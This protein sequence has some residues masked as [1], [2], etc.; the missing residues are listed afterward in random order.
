MGLQRKA[1]FLGCGLYF[2]NLRAEIKSFGLG[3]VRD[4]NPV[5]FLVSVVFA[6][7]VS[8]TQQCI[9]SWRRPSVILG[10]PAT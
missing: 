9:W 3:A 5:H 2:C 7:V 10:F 1:V 8:L 4:S 6:S